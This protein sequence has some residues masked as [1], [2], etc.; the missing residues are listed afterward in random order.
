VSA[1]T[2][3]RDRKPGFLAG[4]RREGV[5][6]IA[7]RARQPV[8]PRHHHHVAG[9]EHGEQP[10]KLRPVRLGSARHLSE[11]PLGSGGAKLAH[12]RRLALP[13]RRLDDA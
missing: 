2:S 1:H 10:A 4:D 5:E 9:G 7:R 3:A 11:H 12:L 6:K 8:E 13:A